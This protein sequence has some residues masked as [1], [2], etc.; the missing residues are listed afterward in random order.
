MRGGKGRQNV[1]DRLGA[2]W[3]QRANIRWVSGPGSYRSR[4]NEF[5]IETRWIVATGSIQVSF[6]ILFLPLTTPSAGFHDDVIW[7]L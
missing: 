7:W 6:A 2:E 3:L 5:R 1:R 4:V